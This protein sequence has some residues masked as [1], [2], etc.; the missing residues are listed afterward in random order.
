[1]DLCQQMQKTQGRW[2]AE[3]GDVLYQEE[4]SEKTWAWPQGR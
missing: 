1:M 3:H 2:F 4:W